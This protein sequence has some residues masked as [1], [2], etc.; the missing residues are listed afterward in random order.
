MTTRWVAVQGV[1]YADARGRERAVDAGGAVPSDVV[2]RSPWLV[3]NGH[4]VAAS[5]AAPEPSAAV[6]EPPTDDIGAASEA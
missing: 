2:E 1:T 5:S 3:E 6:V 4:V